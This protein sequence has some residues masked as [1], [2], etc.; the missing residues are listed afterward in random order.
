[1]ARSFAISEV[2][3]FAG[4]VNQQS[5]AAVGALDSKASVIIGLVTGAILYISNTFG[6]DLVVQ[7]IKTLISLNIP[8]FTAALWLV[9]S[10]FF[11]LSFLSC[12]ICIWPRRGN[13]K[14]GIVFF[15]SISKYRSPEDFI[16][17]VATSNA[18]ERVT[19][20]LQDTHA[21]AKISAKKL[22]WVTWATR[23]LVVGLVILLTAELL[24]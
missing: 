8:N 3:E 7:T 24:S 11:V 17:A 12:V 9:A 2:D 20:V 4:F 19:A 14:A 22:H 6:M 1:M 23:L 18:D 13:Q 10:C 5:S 21:L 16:E 15:K